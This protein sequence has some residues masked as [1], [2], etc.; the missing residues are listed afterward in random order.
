MPTYVTEV[1]A[2]TFVGMFIVCAIAGLAAMLGVWAPPDRK[3]R[4]W[5]I[6]GVVISAVGAVVGGGIRIFGPTGTQAN[7]AQTNSVAPQPGHAP[8]SPSTQAQP[9]AQALVSGF[10]Y[11]EELDGRPTE[12]GVLVLR[13]TSTTPSYSSLRDGAV[14]ETVSTMRIRSGPGRA[15]GIVLELGGQRCVRVLGSPS[16]PLPNIQE[17]SSG[18]WLRV[19][20]QACR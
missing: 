19:Q 12:Y 7:H 13:G 3:V 18:G 2:W 10:A 14:L 20:V 4:T 11:Y 5:L 16:L 6:S 15:H 8:Q 1:I 9:R 17:A